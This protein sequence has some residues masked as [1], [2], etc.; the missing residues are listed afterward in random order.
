MTTKRSNKTRLLLVLICFLAAIAP[1]SAQVD[2]EFWFAFPKTHIVPTGWF[3]QYVDFYDFTPEVN[4]PATIEQPATGGNINVGLATV[5]G[6]YMYENGH[7][8]GLQSYG[9]GNI[10]SVCPYNTVSNWGYRLLSPVD[11]VARMSVFNRNSATYLL[12]GRSALGT[13]FMVP[14]Q[15]Q[16]PNAASCPDSRNSVE[17][18]AT[19]DNTLITVTPTVDLYGGTHPA[20]VPFS[21]S[22]NRGQVYCFAAASQSA[23]GHLGGTTIISDKPVAVDMTDDAVSVDGIHID[24]VCDQLIP[25]SEAGTEYVAVPSPSEAQNTYNG[26]GNDYALIYVLEDNTNVTIHTVGAPTQYTGMQRGDR[27]AYHFSDGTPIHIAADKPVLVFQLTGAYTDLSGHVVAPLRCLKTDKIFFNS[28]AP[29]GGIGTDRVTVTTLLCEQAYINGFASSQ[30]DAS[31]NIVTNYTFTSA[32]WQ[33]VPGTNLF[34]YRQTVTGWY[35]FYTRNT[36][37]PFFAVMMD[38]T[39]SWF[40][41]TLEGGC[42]SMHIADY[43]SHASLAW[44]ATMPTVYCQDDSIFFSYTAENV[45]DLTMLGP[46]GEVIVSDTMMNA[47]PEMSGWYSLRGVLA[48]ECHEDTLY[49]TLRDSIYIQIHSALTETLMDSVCAGNTYHEHGFHISSDHTDSVGRILFDTLRLASSIGC[50]S[51]AIL[52][53]KVIGSPN[54]SIISAGEDFCDAGEQLLTAVSSADNYLWNTGENTPFITA[55]QPGRY[56]VTASDGDC[57]ATAFVDVPTCEFNLYLPNAITPSKADGLNDC[58]AIPAFLHQNISSFNIEIYDR[59]GTLVFQSNNPA[60]RWCGEAAVIPGVY[61]YSIHLKTKDYRTVKLQGT[62]TV[63]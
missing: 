16:F 52:T 10:D 17:V 56:S 36:L 30:F 12:K 26:Q 6:N 60:F 55:T 46:G 20:N 54:L 1:A 28:D 47:V 53:L 59:W 34:Y 27:T 51:V 8:F 45:T 13:R 23:E 49:D 31:N 43:D 15:W 22:L 38:Y 37:G 63:L 32:D 48:S 19:E 5:Y 39:P 33:P 35:N 29:V 57:Q 18:I 24:V 11:I 7:L 2:T 14:A 42:R 41:P 9:T 21:V 62:I 44:D 40:G 58:L 4:F 61:L 3:R 50:D 25:E